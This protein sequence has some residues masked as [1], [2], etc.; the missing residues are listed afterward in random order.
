MRQLGINPSNVILTGGE[1]TRSN[2][3]KQILSDIFNSPCTLVNAQ[4]GAAYGAAI[5]AAV[6]IKVKNSVEELSMEWIKE[7]EE[8]CLVRIL[9]FTRKCI[10]ITLSYIL[11]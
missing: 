10:L 5:F 9:G 8:F 6:G 2:L 1:G 4:E 3:W 11:L 7:T